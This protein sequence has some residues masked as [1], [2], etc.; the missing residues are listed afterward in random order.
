VPVTI[1]VLAIFLSTVL[2]GSQFAVLPGDEISVNNAAAYAVWL[3]LLALAAGTLA[4]AVAPFFGRGAAVGIA[5]AVTFA[6][7]FLNGYQEAIPALAPFA[8]LT[9]FGWTTN[10][11]PLAGQVDWA[12]SD[13]VASSSSCLRPSASRRSPGVTRSHERHPDAAAPACLRACAAR[14]VGSE[15]GHQLS[16]SP[17]A[18][19]SVC[20]V[21]SWPRRVARG[22]TSWRS[23]PS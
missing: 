1:A 5:G 10:H 15:R 19:A 4:F 11:I 8:N 18:S 22:R 21:S 7:F 3:E 20:S 2:V 14:S 12:P 16:P 23:H 9:W 6:G 17:G 13:L